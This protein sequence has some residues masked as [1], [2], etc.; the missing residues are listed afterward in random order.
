MYHHTWPPFIFLKK[1]KKPGN[2]TLS[3]PRSCFAPSSLALNCA[4][5]YK[6]FFVGLGFEFRD[7]CL[8]SRCST[9]WIT[10]PVHFA[11]VTFWKWGLTNYLPGLALN[12]NPPNLSLSVARFTDVSR[13]HLASLF[14]FYFIKLCTLCLTKLIL[15]E[16]SIIISDLLLNSHFLRWPGVRSWRRRMGQIS[17]NAT[18]TLRIMKSRYHNSFLV[19][20]AQP[21]DETWTTDTGWPDSDSLKL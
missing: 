2:P 4:H 18:T 12:S 21:C 11:L 7:S 3:P 9:S 17:R 6:S 13:Q 8:Q 20:I 15:V 1:K 10:P 19:E 16:S 5:S 14:F